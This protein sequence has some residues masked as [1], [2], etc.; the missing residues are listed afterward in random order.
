MRVHSACLRSCACAVGL[1]SRLSLVLFCLVSCYRNVSCK[2]VDL[3]NP[4][5]GT[6]TGE[7][8]GLA[9]ALA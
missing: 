8:E 7:G 1:V 6:G 5:K 4:E 3:K 9:L 2:N